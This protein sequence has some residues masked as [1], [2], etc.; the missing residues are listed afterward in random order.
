[1]ILSFV[2]CVLK[3]LL[4]AC[5]GCKGAQITVSGFGPDVLVLSTKTRPKKL[6]MVGSDGQKYSYLL[7]GRDDLRMHHRLM[8]FVNAAN[9][10]L[11]SDKQT[12]SRGYQAR[13]Y[14]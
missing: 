8:Q 5:T 13:E 1:M 3:Y 4:P 14:R 11:A 7:K 9:S 6:E 2:I 12:G 10:L